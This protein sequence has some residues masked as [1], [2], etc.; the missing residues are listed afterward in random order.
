MAVIGVLAGDEQARRDLRLAIEELGYRAA[1]AADL[2]RA[3]ELVRSE[4]PRLILVAQAPAERTAESLLAELERE[5]PL[6][7]VVVALS[8]RKA[9][10][11]LELLRSGA[12]EVVPPPWTAESL[13]A[14]LKKALRV[15][16]TAL[17]AFRPPERARGALYY[18]AAAAMVA[19]LAF[20]FSALSHRRRLARA[21][22]E[23]VPPSSW[24]LPYAHPAGLAFD[25]REL[26]VSDWYQ[27]AVYRHDAK[28][29]RVRRAVPLPR[30]TPGAVALAG[31][32]LFVAAIPRGFVKHQL[33]ERLRTLGRYDDAAPQTVGMA[34]DGLYLWTCDTAR[35]RLYK[36]ILDSELSVVESFDY[37]GSR[38]AALAFDGTALWS[39]D[40][41]NKELLRHELDRPE[42]VS[43]RVP[44][45][46]YRSGEWEPTGLAWSGEAFWSVAQRARGARGT[47]RL[48]L[49][50]LPP[51]PGEKDAR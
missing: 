40:A 30:E 46:E 24:E 17:E 13:A 50:R 35:K 41:G 11:A 16:G 43:D 49:H 29:L 33:D 15:K 38:P 10:R 47:G 39:L 32:A 7:P 42:G 5:A 23:V 44:L 21:A 34:Y 12:L 14:V 2:K 45:P 9:A 48:F 22:A 6:L 3:L 28:D 37:P 26:W 36:R 18:F 1:P 4:H 25:G 31:D 51:E 20:G 27:E 8:A 19:L